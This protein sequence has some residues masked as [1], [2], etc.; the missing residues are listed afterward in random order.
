MRDLRHRPP[1]CQ[2]KEAEAVLT[3]RDTAL[4]VQA[5]SIAGSGKPTAAGSVLGGDVR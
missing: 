1:R 2:I 5:G 4:R 3:A